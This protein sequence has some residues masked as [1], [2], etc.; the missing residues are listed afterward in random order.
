MSNN[1]LEQQIMNLI[2]NAGCC[3]SLLIQA[4]SA[5]KKKDFSLSNEYMLQ[6]ENILKKAHQIQTELISC[7]QGEG[8]ILVTIIM[9]HAQDHI[10]N[11]VLLM[12]IAKEIIYLHQQK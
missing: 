6:A 5:A 11:A 2:V 10:M 12:D 4:I 3:R 8:K 9:V 7:D 1:I